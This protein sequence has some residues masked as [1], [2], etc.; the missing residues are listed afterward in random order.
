LILILA[1]HGNTFEKG[2]IP[3]V[4]GANEDLPLTATGREQAQLLGRALRIAGIKLDC[5]RAG[6]LSRTLVH[7]QIA[8]TLA[9]Y[10]GDVVVDPALRELDF[11]A[12]TGLSDPELKTIFGEAAVNAWRQAGIRPTDCGWAPAESEVRAN[13]AALA[14]G[15]RGTTLCVTSNG[16]LRYAMELDPKAFA[17]RGRDGGFRVNTGRIC[18]LRRKQLGWKLILW[19]EEPD[20]ASLRTLNH[21]T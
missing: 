19:N 3:R 4:V 10:S 21:A 1:R 18:V 7:A 9:E 6:P 15:V 2:E 12:W 8:A 16:V 20:E 17:G 14:T 13:L 5:V 11:G